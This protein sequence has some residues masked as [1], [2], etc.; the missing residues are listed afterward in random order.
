MCPLRGAAGDNEVIL[1]ANLHEDGDPCRPHLS[2]VQLDAITDRCRVYSRA[3][4]EDK[5]AIV[6]SLIRKGEIVAM[7]GDGVNDAPA[8]KAAHIGIAMGITGTDV[9]KDAA[10]VVLMDDNFC[11]I[12]AAI[13]EGER[14]DCRQR[15]A[16]RFDLRLSVSSVG[17][18]IYGNLQKFVC[19][20]LGTNIGEIIY[21]AVSIAA[22][23]KMPVEAL[24]ILFLNLMSDG[25]PAVALV[26]EPAD[27]DTMNVSL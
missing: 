20:L 15:H 12:A 17:R 8:L 23:M 9:A 19:Y 25:C 11:T 14:R 3:Q 5:T 24:Q 13:E 4:P 27:G 6:N 16:V 2:D 10:D 22:G 26:K 7:T 18:K 21:L 1:C